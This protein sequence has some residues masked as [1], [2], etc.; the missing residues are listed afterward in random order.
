VQTLEQR[1]GLKIACIEEIALSKGF[2]DTAQFARLAEMCGK[3]DYG[4]YLG[5]VLEDSGATPRL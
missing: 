3:S 2:I 1:Q 4:L 5:R